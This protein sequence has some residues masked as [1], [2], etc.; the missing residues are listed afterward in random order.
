MTTKGLRGDGHDAPVIYCRDGSIGLAITAVPASAETDVCKDYRR[1][2]EAYDYAV[3]RFSEARDA[4][5]DY[6]LEYEIWAATQER[7]DRARYAV[8]RTLDEKAGPVFDAMFTLGN[9]LEATRHAV[10]FWWQHTKNFNHAPEYVAA[11]LEDVKRAF[12]TFQSA[13][14]EQV[15]R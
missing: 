5:Q 11:K 7:L 15:C 10:G 12:D 8:R 13:A 2:L 9:A 3:E 4:N 1:A 14:F 6:G